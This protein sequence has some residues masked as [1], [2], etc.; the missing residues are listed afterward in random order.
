MDRIEIISKWLLQTKVINGFKK[1]ITP[2]SYNLLKKK[3]E[4][5]LSDCSTVVALNCITV[6][7]ENKTI[8]SEVDKLGLGGDSSEFSLN[9]KDLQHVFIR[10]IDN[11]Y[12]FREFKNLFKYESIEDIKLMWRGLKTD[13]IDLFFAKIVN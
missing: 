13:N 9:T 8:I 12:S 11:I 4:L 6:F 7:T 10:Y 3:Y 1:D 5:I 2:Y